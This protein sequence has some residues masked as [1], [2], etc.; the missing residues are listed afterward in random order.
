MKVNDYQNTE[1]EELLA[2]L[3]SINS[4]IKKLMLLQ[5]DESLTTKIE[6]YTKGNMS[7][8]RYLMED[9]VAH[10]E[11]HVNQIINPLTK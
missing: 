2:F 10:F 5:D 11:Q 4:R 8:L 9:Y 7:D 3:L 6:L 1:I